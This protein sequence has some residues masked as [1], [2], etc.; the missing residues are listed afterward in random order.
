MKELIEK[1]KDYLTVVQNRTHVILDLDDVMADFPSVWLDYIMKK[2]GKPWAYKAGHYGLEQSIKD[3]LGD[4]G[5]R[6]IKEFYKEGHLRNLPLVEGAKETF[7]LMKNL[8]MK[9]HVLT[10]RPAF[11]WDCIVSDTAYWLAKN[12]F[13][14]DDINFCKDKGGFYNERMWSLFGQ[15]FVIVIEDSYEYAK[16]LSDEGIK[17]YLRARHY[18]MNK[19][20]PENMKLFWNFRDIHHDL[21]KDSVW[22]LDQGKLGQLP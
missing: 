4:E 2:T 21:V 14:V 8:G 19:T 6:L 17:V 18:N 16:D 5:S 11:K 20:L 3:E 15:E 12:G 1:P 9:I 10:G 7:H 13:E 22:S